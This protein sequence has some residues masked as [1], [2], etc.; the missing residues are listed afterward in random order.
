[1]LTVDKSF[2]ATVTESVMTNPGLEAASSSD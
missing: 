2:E 1:M